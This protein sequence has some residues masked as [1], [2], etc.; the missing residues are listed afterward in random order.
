MNHCVKRHLTL[1]LKLVYDKTIQPKRAFQIPFLFRNHKLEIQRGF[2]ADGNL[3]TFKICVTLILAEE[4]NVR[5]QA[6]GF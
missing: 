6:L 2:A 4:L 5:K 3:L 1:Y